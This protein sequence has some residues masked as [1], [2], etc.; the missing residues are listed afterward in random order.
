MNRLMI[1]CLVLLVATSLS[2]AETSKSESVAPGAAEGE[3]VSASGQLDEAALQRQRME[4]IV[5]AI[6]AKHGFEPGYVIAKPIQPEDGRNRVVYVWH[7][8]PYRPL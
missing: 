8:R 2:L 6:Q 4:K 7:P 5:T 3:I 1:L